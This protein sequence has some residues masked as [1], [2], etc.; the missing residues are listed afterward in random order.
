MASRFWVGG[1]GTW[2]ASTTTH[3]SATTGGAGGASVPTTTDDVFVDANSGV[4]TI[5]L[6]VGPEIGSIDFTGYTGTFAGA[7][8]AFGINKTPNGNVTLA[9]GMTISG[10]GVLYHTNVVGTITCNGKSLAALTIGVATGG[11]GAVTF[12]DANTVTG[13]VTLVAGTLNTNGKA[14]TW[15]VFSS[16]NT[17]TRTITMGASAISV[18]G[19]F[20]TVAWDTVTPTGLTI[21]A[22]TAVITLTGSQSRMQTG[23]KNY[24]GTSL[25]FSGFTVAATL[26][27]NGTFANIS[28]IGPANKV[29]SLQFSGGTTT[30]TG[31]LTITGQSLTNRLFFNGN[32]VAGNTVTISAGIVAISNTDFSDVAGSGAAAPFT[33]TS[34]GDAQGN[35][36][37]TFT[38]SATQTWQTTGAGNWS[39]VTKW[40]S[41]VPLPQDDVVIASAFV[42]AP[43][44]TFDM[45]R[46]GRN[47]DLSGSSNAWTLANAA[48]TTSTMYGS[49]TLDS[50]PFTWFSTA[51][52][53]TLAGRGAQTIRC[54]GTVIGNG[55]TVAGFGGTYTLQ[56]D[57]QTGSSAGVKRA[58]AL[59]AGTLDANAHNLTVFSYAPASGTT[60]RM[61][62]GTWTLT[63]TATVWS[64][65]TTATIVPGSSVIDVVDT[66]VT[67]KT[68]TGAGL[69]YSTLRWRS[70]GSGGLVLTGNNTFANLD[71]EATTARTLTLAASASQYVVGALTLQGAT[72]QLLS[73]VSASPGTETVLWAMQGG[74]LANT[75]TSLAAEIILVTGQSFALSNVITDAYR[76]ACATLGTGSTG[77]LCDAFSVPVKVTNQLTNGGFETSTAGWNLEDGPEI[78][79]RITTDSKFGTACMK[80]TMDNN[81]GYTTQGTWWTTA[82]AL[83]L[84]PGWAIAEGVWFRGTPGVHFNLRLEVVNTDTS[85][86]DFDQ[87]IVADGTWQNVSVTGAVAAGKTGDSV[88]LQFYR[89][90][91][92]PVVDFF[93]IDGAQMEWSIVANP[94]VE[95]N[96]S[97]ATRVT[98]A[99]PGNGIGVYQ[100]A[101]NLFRR[102]QCDTTADQFGSTATPPTL[103]TDATVPALFSTQSI[104]VT[105]NG[106]VAGQGYVAQSATGQAAATGLACAS[107]IYFRGV[108]GQSYGVL[109][110]WSNTDASIT[111]GAQT[112]FVA[113]GNWQLLTPA[114]VAVAAGK[115]GD[116]LRIRATING[117][118]AETFWVAHAML[119]SGVAYASPYV[120]SS[121]GATSSKAGGRVQAPSTLINGGSLW[122]AARF[123]TEFAGASVGA[124]FRIIAGWLSPTNAGYQLLYR[125]ASLDWRMRANGN[126]GVTSYDATVLQSPTP[127]TV[128][129]LV[130]KANP[131]TVSVSL[132]GA[133]YATQAV[134]QPVTTTPVA[135]DIGNGSGGQQ[136]D[137]SFLWFACGENTDP[138]AADAAAIAALPNDEPS[139]A[140]LSVPPTAVWDTDSALYEIPPVNTVFPVVA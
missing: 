65:G 63:G 101:S 27:N 77:I 93:L 105:S 59:T 81:P 104:R 125:G 69:T 129:T 133:A 85:R 130:G 50:A 83:G 47:I 10:T 16:S 80:V 21:T 76:A 60:T 84:T 110:E 126:D 30:I 64:A 6:S 109:S 54:N 1:T 123:T 22:N 124:N 96:G 74:T 95:T 102:G 88:Q 58:L 32:G 14:C 35:S 20:P 127:G 79:T 28:F 86:T 73:I 107:S 114:T 131:A 39:D 98:P 62:S 42:A 118:R 103:T 112:I 8:F 75:F 23:A 108:A 5:T 100:P 66:G 37:I 34:L 41:R 56:D 2:D 115:T 78:L 106:A 137:C 17:N 3:W 72:G 55:V 90:S 45:P 122:W 132:N 113:T 24:N 61:G 87:A 43:T 139:F 120:T 52:V 136:S 29:A 48:G 121:G 67:A 135:F 111:Q 138:T 53:L 89:T 49:L 18:S 134:G 91:T 116:A 71:L 44:V 99:A 7:N 46:L 140:H 94:Y 13:T 4:G 19:V 82:T 92:P 40:T 119:Q 33:G 31:T 15:G 57:L 68:F 26:A 25:V 11:T 117:T 70:A 97:I 9:A 36:G 38:P 12:A 128:D 51:T